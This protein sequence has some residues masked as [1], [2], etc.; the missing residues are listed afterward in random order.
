VYDSSSIQ[1]G[2]QSMAKISIKG[3]LVGGVTDVGLSTL[4]GI[5]LAIY[6]VLET[7]IARTPKDQVHSAVSAIM[8]RPMIF[9][10]GMLIGFACSVL[11]GYV[12]ARLAKHD[13]L[14]NGC[15]SSFLCIA[16]GIWLL[17]THQNSDPI[18]QQM[19]EL[20]ASPALGL[21]GGYLRLR[22]RR[23]AILPASASLN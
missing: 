1:E 12:A 11:G 6:A 22:Q 23:P 2:K 4:L 21:L 18:W 13:E 16:G 7:S 14:L 10:T 9:V 3:V 20:V 5:P 19:A 8:H 15:L 17:A